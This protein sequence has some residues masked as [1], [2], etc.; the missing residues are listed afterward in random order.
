MEHRSRKSKVSG[1]DHPELSNGKFLESIYDPVSGYYILDVRGQLVWSC[2][3]ETTDKAVDVYNA[4]VSATLFSNST[5]KNLQ[6][7]SDD[8][9]ASFTVYVSSPSGR[10]ISSGLEML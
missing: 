6:I 3:F 9:S 10:L 2:V 5:T 4:F 1:L 7:Y 8:S